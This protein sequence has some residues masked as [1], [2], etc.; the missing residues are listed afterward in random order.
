MDGAARP[1]V[2]PEIPL[3]CI[4]ENPLLARIKDLRF[5]DPS[6]FVAGEIHHHSEFWQP[7]LA[8]LPHQEFFSKIITEGVDVRDFFRP[9]KGSFRDTEYDV[10]IPPQT[11]LP[12][13]KNCQQFGDFI[14]QEIVDGVQAGSIMRWGKEGECEPPHLVLPLTVEPT[15]PRLCHD[16]RFLNLWIRDLPF[17]LDYITDLPRYVLPGHFQTVFDDKNGYQHVLLHQSSFTFFGFQWLGWYFV[18]RVLPFGW[19]ASAYLYHTLGLAV[20]GAI[21][22][23]GVPVSQYIDDRHAGQ[24]MRPSGSCDPR[25]TSRDR[26]E[27]A[28]Y[29]ACSLLIRAGYFIGLAKSQL[30]PSTTVRF[31]GFQVNSITQAFLIPLDKQEK[32]LAL[33]REILE[34]KWVS[35]RTLQRLAG[36][37]I[38][39]SLAVPMCKLYTREIL[40]TIGFQSKNGQQ[41]VQIKPRLRQELAHWQSPDIWQQHLP[42]R[43]EKHSVV[44]VHSDASKTGWGAVLRQDGREITIHDYWLDAAPH[45]NVLEASALEQALLSLAPRIKNTRVDVWSDSQ[46][47]IHSWNRQGGRN[48]QLNEIFKR[49][50]SCARRHNLD[51]N[52][53]FLPSAS[54]IADVPSRV[55]SDADCTLSSTAWAKVQRRY[56][57]H[58]F[59]LC[60]LDSNAVR[61]TEGNALPHFTPWP[62]PHSAGVNLFAQQIPDDLN[63]YSFPPIV[64]VGPILR[65]LMDLPHVSVT[66]VVFDIHPRRYWW[67]LVQARSVDSLLLGRS[68]DISVLLFPSTAGFVPRPLQY[69]LYA[70]RCVW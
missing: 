52:L 3:T 33:L 23:W 56:G 47:V 43:G 41:V 29:I 39:F 40:A 6:H 51:L 38:S 68:G 14:A 31:L 4:V 21:R 60:A 30:I 70:V 22:S 34:R 9:F 10:P 13:A 19:K 18:F 59:D 61:D 65:L 20:T 24:L 16:E 54:N 1:P 50:V 57:P 25:T 35:Q 45:I 58:A 63:L 5:R 44:E 69:D 64:L 7:L 53:G 32:F 48:S 8:G 42:W 15:K 66:M 37:I 62:T 17:K 67:P 2:G 26:G 36:K 46:V 28:A 49:I 27:A 12:N 11:Y 55:L